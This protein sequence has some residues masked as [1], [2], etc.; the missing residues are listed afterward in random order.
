MIDGRSNLYAS[1]LNDIF[2]R[3]GWHRA[4]FTALAT[5]RHSLVGI[6]YRS[7]KYGKLRVVNCDA[8]GLAT[9]L[10]P[11]AG[12]PGCRAA[13]EGLLDRKESATAAPVQQMLDLSEPIARRSMRP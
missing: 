13:F 3:I 2:A 5:E 9:W 4:G 6:Q 12:K 10:R 1:T 7:P 11:R 8:A